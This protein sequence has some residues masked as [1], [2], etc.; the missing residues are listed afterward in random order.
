MS[1]RRFVLI[2]MAISAAA[3]SGCG[4]GDE[5][6]PSTVLSQ[7]EFNALVEDEIVACMQDRGFAYEPVV[8]P[9]PES[10]RPGI[11]S[12][13]AVIDSLEAQLLRDA[14]ALEDELDPDAAGAEP[15]TSAEYDAALHGEPG[16]QSPGCTSLALQVVLDAN[17]EFQS[18]FDTVDP[19][20]LDIELQRLYASAEYTGILQDLDACV[21]DE[22]GVTEATRLDQLVA[23]EMLSSADLGSSSIQAKATELRALVE[24]LDETCGQLF[25]DIAQLERDVIEGV[26][27]SGS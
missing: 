7:V 5:A 20:G 22:A 18:F 3:L 11:Q 26:E 2:V 1:L 6:A 13:L 14:A 19:P 16:S 21:R 8:R 25:Q 24:K 17:P 9:A 23:R 4:S 12:A 27:S 10:D 15:S